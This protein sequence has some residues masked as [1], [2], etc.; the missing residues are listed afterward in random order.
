[1]QTVTTL[2]TKGLVTIPKAMR[3]AA[4]LD[5]GGTIKISLQ[6]GKVLIEPA[7]VVTY[8]VRHYTDKEIE[9]FLEEDKKIDPK[10]IRALDRKFGIK[11]DIK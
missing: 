1:M 11:L 6:D 8:P 10:I 2:Q 5:E 3:Q 9:E 4:G 7:T